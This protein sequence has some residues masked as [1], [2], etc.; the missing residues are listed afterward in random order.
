MLVTIV[1]G[2]YDNIESGNQ[3]RRQEL[4]FEVDLIRPHT[5]AHHDQDFR[6]GEITSVDTKPEVSKCLLHLKIKELVMIFPQG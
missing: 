6:I 5:F 4:H 3:D 2:T 1:N